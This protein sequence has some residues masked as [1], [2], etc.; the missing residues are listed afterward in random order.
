MIDMGIPKEF[1]ISYK[2]QK[3]LRHKY[4]S[5]LER[6]K[7]RVRN[8]QSVDVLDALTQELVGILATRYKQLNGQKL[9]DS[10]GEKFME[11]SGKK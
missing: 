8:E 3:K 6:L 11:F 2:I 4:G 7:L 5:F 10:D 1:V 9:E